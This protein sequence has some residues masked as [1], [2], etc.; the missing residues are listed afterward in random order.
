MNAIQILSFVGFTLLV[1]IITWF[2]VRKAD[3]GSQQGYFL[4]GRSL[5]APVIAA[6]LMLTNLSTEQLVGL[7]GQAYKSGMSVMGWE[8]TSAV[9]LIFLALIFLPRYL[10]RGIATIPDFL[11]ERYDKTTRIIIDFCFLIA[12][13]ICFLPIVL[14]SGALALNSLFHIGESLGL[15]QGA[16]I[17]LLVILLGLA[18]ILYAVIGG[19]RAMA[20]A[21]SINGI[22][23][24]IGGLMVSI[25]GLMAMGK[26]SFLQ[27][28]EQL[29]TVHAEKLNSIGGSSDPLPIGAAFTGLILVNTFYWC[30]NQ[31]IVQRTL[32][33]K[34]LA[35]GQKGA[36]LTAVLK[37]LDPL[38]LVLPGLIAFHLYQ[39]LPSA[40]MAYPTLV[41]KVM[42]LPLVGFFGAV[43]FGAVIS[44]FNG[45]LN[46]ASTLFSM[47]IY[48]RIINEN[49]QPEQLVRIG[50]KFGLFIAVIS[51]I[52]APW[53]A[54]A[55]QG[56]YS[57]MKQ[58]NGIYNVPLVT[59]IIMGFF[60]PRIPAI[61]A[62][63][64]MGL[65][66][67]SYITINYLVKFDFH[68]LYVLACTFCINV[69]VMLVIGFIK[70]RAT[71]FT[72]HDAFAVDM[73]PYRHVKIASVGIL[74]AMI[75]VYAGLAEFGGYGTRWL[76]AVSYAIT[77]AVIIYLIYSSWRERRSAP[78]SYAIDVKEKS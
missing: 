9:T 4:A 57:W 28:I 56:L 47:G 53:I 70:P 29:T 2:K 6:S 73:Q 46:S 65:G 20:I 23:L 34:S 42:P 76:A 41:N 14:Y 38:I 13:G 75:G 37:M 45:F 24:V 74:F 25:F 22:G 19:M 62:K 30:T 40:D 50:R 16:A 18:G 71:P 48:R 7:S 43:L 49:A 54:N 64:A 36:L 52:V 39:D 72:F 60:F 1:A 58:L 8:V 35:E 21:D 15:T 26:G 55:P 10:Q 27:G 33:S 44:T 69:V 68:F 51:V 31:G 61:A 66:I 11:E 12:T 17:W 78:A 32:A 67:V 3:T 5:K 59:I 63:V 77:A